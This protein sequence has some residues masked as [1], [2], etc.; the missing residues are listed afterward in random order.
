MWDDTYRFVQDGNQAYIDSNMAWASLE[1]ASNINLVYICDL[2]GRVVW[3]E[4][5]DSSK[6]GR[7]AVE[8]FPDKSL[9]KDHFLLRHESLS[10]DRTGVILTSHG[11]M[12]VSSRPVVR[13]SGEGPRRGVLIM[14]RFLDEDVVETLREQTRVD[15]RIKD[16]RGA[17]LDEHERSILARLSF[18][19]WV[20]EEAGADLLQAY[21]MV[22]DLEGNPALLVTARAPREIM[23]RGRAAARFA[24]LAVLLTAIATLVIGALIVM[25]V[26]NLVRG[27][28]ARLSP[29]A[30]GLRDRVA[31]ALVMS[32]G[33]VL[34]VA[35]FSI[36]RGREREEE[37]SHFKEEAEERISLFRSS[38]DHHL[39]I[40][41]SLSRLYESS[42]EVE[43][44]EFGSFV[45]G[46]LLERPEV[47]A[48]EWVPRVADADRPSYENSA[49]REGVDGYAI[50]ERSADGAMIAAQR[51]DV[52]Y[53]VL[54]VEPLAGNEAALGFDLGS[55]AAY[56]TALE[57][58]RDTGR[59][60][61]TSRLALVVEPGKQDGIVV[62]V[63]F[64][65]PGTE[66]G[67]I[68]ARRERLEGFVVAALRV[69]AILE[70]ALSDVDPGEIDIRVLDQSAPEGNRLLCV[71]ASG[72]RAE[73]PVSA[74]KVESA[75]S[76]GLRHA[77]EVDVAGRRWLVVC[78]PGPAF[79][80]AH[81]PWQSWIA[82]AGGLLLSASLTT[83]V[84]GSRRRT[85]HIA[86]LVDRRTAELRES[87]QRFR[88]VTLSSFD[89]IW[90]IDAEGKYTYVSD[91]VTEVLGYL[92]RDLLG[93]SP[94]DLMPEE[95]ARR[96]REMFL[97]IGSK[98]A[99]ITDLEN[100]NVHKDGHLVCLLTNGVPMLDEEGNL[101]GYRGVDKDITRRKRTERALRE[102]EERYRGLVAH[103]P[104]GLYRNTPGPEGSF[105]MANPAIVRMFGYES[106]E[107]F[108]KVRVS[109]L[110]ANP[111][112]REAF[113]EKL[114]A[115][116]R[117]VAEELRLRKKDGTPIWAAVTANAVR[118]DSG[119]IECFDGSVQDI[120]DRKRLEEERV[121]LS[122]HL[123]QAQ[124]QE[125]LKVMAGSIAHNFNNMLM[126]VLGYLD[127]ALADLPPESAARQS[128][129]EADKAAK[130]AAEMSTLMLTYVGQGK[131]VMRPVNVSELVEGTVDLFGGIIPD[132]I[133]RT[134]IL[135]R[136]PE[137]ILGDPAQI[138]QVIMNLI[139]NAAE[140]IG[141]A[142]G[143]ISIATKVLDCDPD[144][145]GGTYLH[146]DLPGGKYA[147]FEVGDTGCGMDSETLA[148]AF[149]PFFTTK[150]T[151]RGL[152]LAAVVGIVRGHRGAIDVRSEPGKGTTVRVLLPVSGKPAD[153]LAKQ[154][155]AGESR[156]ETGTV[157][158]VD[159]EDAVRDVGRQ[160][161]E[162]AGYTVLTALGG[163]EA[164]ELFR[165]RADGIDC[166]LLDLRMPGMSGAEALDQMRRIR[167]DVR[168]IIS[169]GFSADEVGDQLRG[170]DI[171][172]FIQKPYRSSTMIAK[173]RE[174]LACRG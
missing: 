68:E 138:Q 122:A 129:I 16:A 19:A 157:L 29:A 27:E 120:T 137:T 134:T 161:L 56:R 143:T 167:R 153:A 158:L 59:A 141:D 106:E 4:A 61:A 36:L 20:I 51:R 103:L 107:E 116:G 90:E 113:S 14:G 28:G 84:V 163:R 111:R 49:C 97:A 119:E 44:Q 147:T 98:K 164:V 15:F 85:A 42:R 162:R 165:E 24:S 171:A 77:R 93:R 105:I 34:T 62:F 48:F 169:S 81:R 46:V 50:R 100:W 125:S 155:A 146:P 26:A 71:H 112:D 83:Y 115:R 6:G 131:D 30:W 114:A 10:S 94:F 144:Y 95:E 7:I 139:R 149:D 43:R 33:L 160:I 18:Q 76:S 135:A 70:A 58:A 17:E 75:D 89:W 38:M 173:L 127:L 101:L 79:L 121:Q 123:Y 8:E 156:G 152:G 126:A 64:Y 130:R 117:V 39:V 102:S 41:E 118:D 23:A 63:P 88:D 21:G 80:A 174:A 52:Y 154:P 148:K 170:R 5:H 128:I 78:A 145:L 60:A 168:V 1:G 13:S 69:G 151:G 9:P 55:E 32:A 37:R 73:K 136:E 47:Q 142:D 150:F 132:G 31:V 99:R 108:F 54:Y 12:L 159:D 91:T 66:V 86:A 65:R 3:G 133:S 25:M 74:L 40:L 11:P 57:Q 35:A 2:T 109:D 124:K 92:P 67:T 104:I 22:S 53:P 87:E 96:T 172:G 45:S 166:V 140:A 72:A 110:Y 82:L